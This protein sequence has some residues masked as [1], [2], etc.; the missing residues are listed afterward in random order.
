MKYTS[1]KP[2]HFNNI[3]KLLK[4]VKRKKTSLKPA[5]LPNEMLCS[6]YIG[7]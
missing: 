7:F 6:D 5:L 1:N 3:Y 2:Y 4:L